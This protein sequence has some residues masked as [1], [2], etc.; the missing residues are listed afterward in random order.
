[1]SRDAPSEGAVAE[2]RVWARAGARGAL[3]RRSETALWPLA[4]TV[5]LLLFCALDVVLLPDLDGALQLPGG[6]ATWAVMVLAPC[7]GSVHGV[8]WRLLLGASARLPV[9]LRVASWF[10]AACATA[11]LISMS[12]SGFSRLGGRYTLH[13]VAVLVLSF[14]GCGL[15]AALA[16][17]LSGG[18]G[19]AGWLMRATLRVRFAMSAALLAAGGLVYVADRSFYAQLYPHAHLALRLFAWWVSMFGLVLAARDVALPR[20]SWAVWT[21]AVLAGLALGARGH[22]LPWAETFGTRPWPALVLDAARAATDVDRDGYSGLFGGGDCAPWDPNVHPGAREIPGNG[23]D[24]NCLLGDAPLHVVTPEQQDPAALDPPA[25]VEP[26]PMDIVLLTVDSLRPDHMGVYNRAYGP[27]G[28]GTTPN[29]DAFAKDAVVFERAYTPGGGT[30]IAIGSMLRGLFPRKLQ[31]AAYY[32]TDRFT[33]V[34]DLASVPRGHRVTSMF[35]LAFDDPRPPLPLLLQQRGM[36]TVAV[37][38]DGYSEILSRGTGIERGF[39]SFSETDWRPRTERDDAGT[40]NVVIQ[41][42]RYAPKD[43]RLFVWAHFFGPHSPNTEHEGARKYGDSLADGYDHEINYLDQHIGRVLKELRK[44]KRQAAVFISSDHGD[45]MANGRYHGYTISD[46]VARIPLIARVPGWPARRIDAPVSLVD[47]MPTILELT[48]TPAPRHLD[49]VPLSRFVLSPN[50]KLDRVL[51]SDTWLYSAEAKARVDQASAYNATGKIVL[52]RLTQRRYL[53]YGRQPSQLL[54]GRTQLE[55]AL[56][57]YLEET[58]GAI[59]LKQH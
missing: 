15:L 32:E 58:G 34:S 21:G 6:A 45:V 8:L 17:G 39:D 12:L 5:P 53:E 27:D 44:S 59:Q 11:T 54:Q 19:G 40:A 22:D 47:L 26:A 13:A 48:K 43:R 46:A 35:P 56:D 25:P 50:V 36:H 20:W 24:D 18:R 4:S 2:G 29:I 38:D 49:G 14:G 1:V 33:I 31:W 3:T 41:K 28:R 51:F 52:D 30:N 42:L 55:Q 23:I 7:V 16:L 9:R 10:V 37:L 57:A